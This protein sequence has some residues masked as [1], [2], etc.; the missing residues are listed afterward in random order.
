MDN[1]TEFMENLQ[2]II[3]ILGVYIAYNP[4]LFCRTLKIINQNLDK[5]ANSAFKMAG[6]YFLPALCIVM[7]EN[8]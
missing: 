8:H 4:V 3:R 6:E 5:F 2:K 1:A 7:P